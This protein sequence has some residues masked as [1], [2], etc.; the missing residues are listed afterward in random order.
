MTVLS[1]KTSNVLK[2]AT[3]QQPMFVGDGTKAYHSV[4]YVHT[5]GNVMQ[6]RKHDVSHKSTY[7]ASHI[8]QH[9]RLTLYIRE[10][11]VYSLFYLFV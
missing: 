4:P 3:I 2:N 11:N 7:V 8:Y 6:R 10:L 5:K 1:T 9:R